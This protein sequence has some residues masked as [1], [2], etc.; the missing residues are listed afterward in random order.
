MS[1]LN[2]SFF[3]SLLALSSHAKPTSPRAAPHII[4][5]L[6]DDFGWNEVGYHQPSDTPE[7]EIEVQTP[8]IDQLKEEGL[9]LDRMYVH[10]ICSPSR[11][12]VQTGRDAIHVNVQNVHPEVTNSNDPIGGFQ[13][14]PLN[15]STIAEV[16][17][18]T[19]KYETSFVGKWDVGMATE[20]HTPYS[21]GYEKFFGYF[22]HSND[23]WNFNEQKCSLKNIKDL[24][25]HNKTFSGPAVHLE[26]GAHCS[27]D[28]QS[29]DGERCVYEE[30]LLMGSVKQQIKDYA[31]GDQEKSLFMFWS[32]H[33]VHMPLQVPDSYLDK[34]SDVDDSN[35]RSMRAMSNYLDT[36]IGEVVDTL[37]ET[38]LW[39]DTVLVFHADN[40]GEIMTQS[41]GG[42][43]YPLRGGKFSNFEGGIRVNAIVSGGFLPEERRGKVEDRLFTSSDWLKTYAGLAGVDTDSLSDAKAVDNG[44]PDYDSVNQWPIISGQGEDD[45]V[46]REEV[47]IGDTTSVEFNGDGD[48]L[49]GGLIKGR[50]KLLLGAKNKLYR[51]SQ[52]VVTSVN[53]PSKPM[54]VPELIFRTCSRTLKNACLF[55][56]YAD[57]SETTNVA[58]EN[59]DVFNEML[60]RIDEIQ[61][62]VYSPDRGKKDKRACKVAKDEYGDWWGPFL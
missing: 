18:D 53:Y 41:C 4:H 8:N 47:I 43:N 48:T 2:L 54:I 13:G 51:I 60:A 44:L 39:E 23:Y 10:K 42:N 40:G 49:V 15:M 22:H 24:W 36:E 27:Q 46:A 9:E 34:F 37:K 29:P 11:S 31:A 26:N 38:G 3:L 56:I 50:W 25:L 14:I 17:S 30:E 5:I 7:D 19:G 35:R 20:D 61:E 62:S 59:E 52:D 45:E 55:D 12:S 32:T 28:N 58:E 21:R 57:P 33:L 1:L 16:L 6:V